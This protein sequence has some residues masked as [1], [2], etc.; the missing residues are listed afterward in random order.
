[1]L[2]VADEAKFLESLRRDEEC[3]VFEFEVYNVRKVR[4]ELA[5]QASFFSLGG[6]VRR[7]SKECVFCKVVSPLSN[8][9]NLAAFLKGLNQYPKNR[10]VAKQR[11]PIKS[12]NE[13]DL[14]MASSRRFLVHSPPLALKDHKSP[15]LKEGESMDN[16]S[17]VSSHSSST[18]SVR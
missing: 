9:D 13:Q 10:L 18:A 14:D 3:Y 11:C 17:V 1:M 7:T 6:F 2:F 12:S 5:S 8:S 15:D 16:V 4:S